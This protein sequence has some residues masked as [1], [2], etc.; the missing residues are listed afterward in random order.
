[1]TSAHPTHMRCRHPNLGRLA[2]PRDY[3]RMAE[4]HAAG[5]VW[6]ADNGAFGGLDERAWRRMLGALAGVAGCIFAAVPDEVGD[7]DTTA[8]M[9]QLYAPEVIDAG[10]PPAWVA[11]DGAGAG[12]IPGDARAVFIGG[13]TTYKLGNDARAVI[14][15]AKRHGLW[16]H[17]GR[18]NTF[19]RLRYC[20][21][22]GADSVDGSKW[23]MFRDTYLP[24]CLDFLRGGEQMALTG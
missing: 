22:V 5:V 12:D 8:R 23:P 20:Q 18:V 11:Q 2:V 17:V 15:E 7:A 16:V 10:L 24:R 19:G 21:A 13:S 14:A 4:T 9:W 1:M 3:A 6:A